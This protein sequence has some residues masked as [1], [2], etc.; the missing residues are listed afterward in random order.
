MEG[1]VKLRVVVEYALDG[2]VG[3]E[4]DRRARYETAGSRTP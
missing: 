3:G 2:G 1:R 4:G